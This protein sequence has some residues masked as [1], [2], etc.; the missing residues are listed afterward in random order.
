MQDLPWQKSFVT[1]A[2]QHK[3]DVI[4]IHVSGQNTKRFYR[5]ANLRKFFRIKWNIEMFYL[6]DESYRH[7]NKTFT[8]TIGKPIPWSTFDKSRR[9]QEWATL[10]RELVYRLPVEENPGLP[11][12]E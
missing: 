1:K 10:V 5:I 8:F 3:R 11:E 6:P 2:I 4:P 7:R 9:P 12:G